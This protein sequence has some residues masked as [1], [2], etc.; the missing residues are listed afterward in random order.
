MLRRWRWSLQ[1]HLLCWRR[2]RVHGRRRCSFVC[3]HSSDFGD[4]LGILFVTHASDIRRLAIAHRISHRCRFRCRRSIP[5]CRF[6]CPG[7]APRW[8]A[9]RLDHSPLRGG[10]PEAPP[11]QHSRHVDCPAAPR[12]R[13]PCRSVEDPELGGGL[14]AHA[15]SLGRAE[16]EQ[17]LQQRAGLVEGLG[18]RTANEDVW[19]LVVGL[20]ASRVARLPRALAAHNDGRARLSLHPLLRA[21][22]RPD[23]H[24]HHA[25]GPAGRRVVRQNQLERHELTGPDVT[26]SILDCAEG[27]DQ[28]DSCAEQ[29]H[30]LG[31]IGLGKTKQQVDLTDPEHERVDGDGAA[32]AGLIPPQRM[33]RR[34]K[35]AYS[36]FKCSACSEG[37]NC[38]WRLP[39]SGM[40][41]S[42]SLDAAASGA[43]GLPGATSTATAADSS[44]A[45]AMVVATDVADRPVDVLV[46]VSLSAS[47]VSSSSC[48][49]RARQPGPV[50]RQRHRIH[51]SSRALDHAGTTE[52]AGWQRRS[53][54]AVAALSDPTW[55]RDLHNWRRRVCCVGAVLS[56]PRRTQLGFWPR[57]LTMC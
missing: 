9:R 28:L 1:Q 51:S 24:P 15:L 47:C 26:P 17:C 13:L 16:V 32:T 57:P 45:S 11:G 54:A 31:T 48:C 23:D 19:R 33:R 18:G 52:C 49:M 46:V 4:E 22:A 35:R 40:A 3:R 14:A 56:W 42:G 29:T 41:T 53:C 7:P 25:Q 21:A 34:F 8:P 5:R 6:H 44:L 2:P 12:V 55:A 30:A 43:K 20:V 27:S 10:T 38:V 50:H 36:T 39:N 37:S